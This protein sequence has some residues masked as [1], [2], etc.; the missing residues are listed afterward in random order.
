MAHDRVKMKDRIE[1]CLELTILFRT[2][3]DFHDDT[4][5][6]HAKEIG[7]IR[8]NHYARNTLQ[9]DARFPMA[10]I[11]IARNPHQGLVV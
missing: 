7:A 10:Y 5:V 11:R 2:F 1:G 8:F 9:S 3:G 6:R 4:G